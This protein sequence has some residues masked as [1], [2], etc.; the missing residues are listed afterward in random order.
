MRTRH[1]DPPARLAVRQERT[2]QCDLAVVF[3]RDNADRRQ[4]RWRRNVLNKGIG[5][6]SSQEQ[7]WLSLSL[8]L[9]FSIFPVASFS[10]GKG[11]F[12]LHGGYSTIWLMICFIWGCILKDNIEIILQRRRLNLF[13]IG[14]V[15]A[16][17]GIPVA[18]HLSG[19][20]LH[21]IFMSYLSPFCILEAVCLFIL[22]YQIRINGCRIRKII[23]SLSS[24]ALGIYLLQ[25]HPLIWNNFIIVRPLETLT[26]PQYAALLAILSLLLGS[27][28][29]LLNVIIERIYS[30]CRMPSFVV[31]MYHAVAA[32]FH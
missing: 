13:L 16:A 24:N 7:F 32:V 21:G 25:A 28:G 2:V 31:W 18:F 3:S 4:K 6:C 1:N 9:M 23:V 30:F 22:F 10:V 27:V 17:I 29:I 8:F 5:K 14:G 12:A 20:R 11:A 19:F 15:V 26:L